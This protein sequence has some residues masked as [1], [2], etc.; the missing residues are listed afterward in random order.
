M[1]QARPILVIGANGRMGRTIS[2]LVLN[3]SEFTL[4]GCVDSTACV[5]EVSLRMVGK[6]PVSDNLNDLIYRVPKETVL[7]DFTAPQVSLNSAR[8]A[9][10]AGFPLIIGTTGLNQAELAELEKLAQDSLLF[11]SSNMSIGISVIRKILPQLA[12]AL[13]DVHQSSHHG[14]RVEHL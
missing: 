12:A 3:S 7:I 1:A 8:V 14:W 9:S 4:A 11:W 2:D 5:A 13:G 10:Q 6:C